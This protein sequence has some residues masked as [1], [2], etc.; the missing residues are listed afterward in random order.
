MTNKGQPHYIYADPDHKI[1]LEEL[2]KA[3]RNNRENPRL[4]YLMLV[5]YYY[6]LRIS[7]A[8]SLEKRNFKIYR[9]KKSDKE[10]LQVT[11]RTLKN[12]KDKSRTL[13]VPINQPY[14]MELYQFVRASPDNQVFNISRQWARVLIQRLMPNVSPHVFRHSILNGLAQ[15]EETE[16]ALQSFAGWSDSRPAKSYVQRVST[17][18][19]ADRFYGS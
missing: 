6:G 12:R 11:T 1:T 16:F 13:Y 2:E 7:E 4:N 17:R 18:K 15:D 5:L 10:Y 19:I 8:L 9:D 14:I 3:I